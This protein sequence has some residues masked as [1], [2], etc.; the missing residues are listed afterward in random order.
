MRYSEFLAA[1]F[2]DGRVSVP[3]LAPL[4]ETE[5]SAG[6][7]FL[8]DF[9]HVYRSEMPLGIPEFVAS[10]GRWAATRFY[11]ACQCAVFRDIDA[12]VVGTLLSD[13]PPAPRSAEVHYSVDL[14][15]RFLPDLATFVGTAAA[16]DPLL[17]VLKR[18]AAE[19]PLSSV[20]MRDIHGIETGVIVRSSALTR[21]YVDRVISRG[22]TSRLSDVAVR[23][24]VNASLG[25]YPELAEGMSRAAAEQDSIK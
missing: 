17:D 2:E 8:A 11:Q 3:E 9:E 24:A 19:W 7:A 1:L 21:V 22:D 10:A 13:P 23:D 20:G 16:K 18:W 12:E 14:T 15:F 25:L 6:D 4:D 5:L